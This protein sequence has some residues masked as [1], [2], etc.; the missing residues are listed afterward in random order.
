[1]RLAAYIRRSTDKQ[2]ASPETQRQLI[3][4]WATANEHEVVQW[5]IEEPISG[6]KKGIDR[7][8]VL[9]DMLAQVKAQGRLADGVVVWK[10][11]RLAREPGTEYQILAVLDAC[12]CSLYSVTET[13]DRE[14]AQGRLIH[15]VM[16][17][18]RAFERELTAE[19]VYG[20]NLA[21]MLQGKWPGGRPP[22]GYV[23]DKQTKTVSVDGE[24]AA[25]A[26]AVF[27]AY[28]RTAGNS[29]QAA[30]LLNVQGF[31]TRD[32]NP[33]R[34]DAVRTVVKSSIYRRRLSY[35]G[36]AVA[37][38]ELIPPLIPDLLIDSADAVMTSAGMQHRRQKGSKQAYSGFLL[39]SECGSRMKIHRMTPEKF[40]WVCRAA[41]E[42]RTC[43]SG[44]VA[45]KYVD[46][47]VGKAIADLLQRYRSALLDAPDPTPKQQQ[48]K[49]SDIRATLLSKAD[50]LKELYIEGAI[51]R[52]E[53]D[54]RTR[55]VQAELTALQP[56][57]EKTVSETILESTID[58]M[59]SHWPEIPEEEKRT[60]LALLG[61]RIVVNTGKR[62]LWIELHANGIEP[63]VARCKWT[64]QR[65]DPQ[66]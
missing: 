27:E 54:R 37:A 26:V 19:R 12:K 20:A 16:M 18:F 64:S 9:A 34:D 36:Y 28:V 25:D 7:R 40:R 23:Y 44:S 50:R 2:D 32:G 63:I 66:H 4:A 58:L 13:I 6:G 3:S 57:Q 61:V 24:R 55:E 5:H 48:R 43:A 39:C 15:H 29:S 30:R 53:F 41:K 31:V 42:Q 49:R 1:M 33:W 8:P 60:L 22:L 45:N 17:G 10:L 52:S 62:P 46:R 51:N 14:S 65:K 38:P 35:D 59:G 47:L 21:R 56:V 11:D